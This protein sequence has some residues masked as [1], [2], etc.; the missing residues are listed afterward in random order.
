MNMAQ[1]LIAIGLGEVNVAYM[2]HLL[3]GML[4]CGHCVLRF[5]HTLRNP[6]VGKIIRNP[7]PRR[8][9]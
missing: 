3:Q 9:S 1:L 4:S 5:R 6:H 7:N 8:H 2:H